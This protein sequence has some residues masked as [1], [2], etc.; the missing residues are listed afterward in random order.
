MILGEGLLLRAPVAADRPRWLELMH[1]PAQQAYGSPAFVRVPRTV[2]DLDGRV[3]EATERLAAGEPGTLVIADTAAPEHFLGDVAW[4]YDVPAALR[5]AD[6]G[7]A[8]H[9][10]A[11]GRSIARRAVRTF[12]RWLT[13]DEDG[14]GL[15]RVQLDHSVENPASC[16]VALAAG[17][18]RE[19]I[20]RAFLPL[21]DPDSPDGQRRHD[22]C[23]HGFVPAT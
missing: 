6:I 12:A 7:Y 10:D 1:D 14:P 22:V 21:R 4:R 19:G 13:I 2:E 11:R 5:I 20:R 3:A 15:A 9:P 16:H 18:E 8:V 23:L 17:F